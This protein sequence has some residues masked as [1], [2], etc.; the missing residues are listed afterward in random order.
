MEFVPVQVAVTVGATQA[1]LVA[2]I[3]TLDKGSEVILPEPFFDLYV[4]QVAL[5][6]GVT[7]PAPMTVD[8]EGEWR[9]SEKTLR[10][11]ITPRSRVLIVN[12]PHNPTGK[13][14]DREELET[15]ARVVRDENRN[16]LPGDELLVIADEV[17]KTS[18]TATSNT[19][20]SPRYQI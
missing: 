2:L 15:I 1:L 14:F 20:T 11:A 12:S 8:N 10:A 16:R 18:A 17:Y 4:G 6:G 19:S 3:A 7:K 13:V 5:A 9:L